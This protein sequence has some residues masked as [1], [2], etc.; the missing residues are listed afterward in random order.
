MSTPFCSVS[1]VDFEQ[2]FICLEGYSWNV[3]ISKIYDMRKYYGSVL[4]QC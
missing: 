3:S 2:V 1:T 4:T